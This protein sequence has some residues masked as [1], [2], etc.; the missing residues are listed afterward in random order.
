MKRERWLTLEEAARRLD[1]SRSTIFRML[2]RGLLTTVCSGRRRL[3]SERSVAARAEL[4]VLRFA[5]YSLD[6]PFR[7]LIGRFQGDGRGPGS[8][9]KAYYLYA[10]GSRPR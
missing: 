4:P 7:K 5:P 3:V 10:R 8:E 6:H 2:R 1:V 9:D